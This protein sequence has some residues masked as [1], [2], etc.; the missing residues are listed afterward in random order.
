[1]RVHQFREKIIPLREKG[2]EYSERW[3][4]AMQLNRLYLLESQKGLLQ[5]RR[6]YFQAL[7]ERQRA[8]VNLELHMGGRLP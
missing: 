7:M 8:L 4:K 1:M 2:I 6:E 5:S 3:V